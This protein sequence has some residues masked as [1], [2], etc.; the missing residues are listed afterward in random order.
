MTA[1]ELRAALDGRLVGPADAVVSSISQDSR[2]VVPGALFCCIRG[3]LHDGHDHAVEAVERGASALLVEREVVDPLIAGIPQIVVPDVRAVVGR[4]AAAVFGRPA[5]ALMTVGVTGTNGKT[6]VT[7]MIGHIADRCGH[8]VDVIGTLSGARTTPEASELHER[9]ARDVAAGIELVALEVSSHALVLGRVDGLCLDVAVFTNLGVDHLDFHGDMESYFRA[10][11]TLFEP[12]RSRRAVI[13]VGDAWGQRLAREAT[14]PVE[15]VDIED[16]VDLHWDG[17]AWSWTWRGAR[18][19]LERP[20]EHDVANALVACS[21]AAALGLDAAEIARAVEPTPTVPGRFER[22]EVDGNDHP[23][24]VVDFA[25]TPDALRSV[26]TAARR[27][28]A[29]DGRVV[30]VFGCGGD[31][32]RTKRPAMGEVAA[33]LSD[34]AYLS[35]DNPRSEDPATIRSEVAAG[36]PAALRSRLVEV[37]DRRAAIREAVRS[38]GQGDVVVIAGKGHET[39]QTTG[40]VTVPFDDRLVAAEELRGRGSSGAAP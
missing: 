36:V 35:D 31:R 7:T 18:V 26:L 32:D 13:W 11:A 16:A 12:S 23:L 10:K 30:T 9:L 38:T 25:H 19:R 6:T 2:L 33:A 15:R 29:A 40:H 34:V 14:G 20:G 39:G 5:E 28:A 27:A 37:A 17:A 3:D 21:A 1:G 8:P 22:V 4:T 24:V